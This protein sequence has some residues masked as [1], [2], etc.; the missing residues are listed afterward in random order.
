MS[1]P[2]PQDLFHARLARLLLARD[3]TRARLIE[4]TADIIAILERNG[5]PVSTADPLRK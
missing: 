4:V 2:R 1:A 5:I 3:E